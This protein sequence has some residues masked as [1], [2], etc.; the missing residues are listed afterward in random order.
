MRLSRNDF[1]FAHVQN[2]FAFTRVR[3]GFALARAQ[4]GMHA[5]M[6]KLSIYYTNKLVS[7]HHNLINRMQHNTA[8]SRRRC[9]ANKLSIALDDQKMAK[10]QQRGEGTHEHALPRHP[11][12]P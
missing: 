5:I 8:H 12:S 9:T 1:A 6:S 4:D 2:G 11:A 3:N 7:K 10:E